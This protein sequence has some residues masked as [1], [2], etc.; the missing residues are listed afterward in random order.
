MTAKTLEEARKG[1]DRA[2]EAVRREFNTVRT[3]K[4]TPALL[5][6]VRVE[7]YGST[8][9]LNQVANVSA[10]EAGLLVVQPYDQNIAGQI[11]QAIQSGDLGLNPSVDGAIIRVPIPPLSEERRKEMVKV[12]HRMAEEGRISV[13]HVRQET[14]NE[15]QRMERD[16]E[17]GKDEIHRRLDELQE[18]T[19]RHIATIDELLK[20]REAE[21]MEV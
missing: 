6:T 3:G 8:M 17:A 14:R 11:A 18:I 10:P 15:L 4:A 5:D 20:K 7:A 1:M 16:G 12:L 9:A 2:V 13:R 21:V 19:D